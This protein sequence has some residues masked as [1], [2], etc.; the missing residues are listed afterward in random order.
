MIV[1]GLEAVQ[2]LA[3]F[4]LDRTLI[5]L[6]AGFLRRA[7]EFAEQRRLGPE[8]VAWL[9]ALDR[10]VHP[11]RDI[12]FARVRERYKL[13]APVKELLAACRRRMPYLVQ[14]YP[15]VPTGLA[16]LRTRGWRVGVTTNGMPDSQ[17]GKLRRTGL[18]DVIDG[19]AV[20]EAEGIRKP[21]VDLF[22]IAAQR[23]GGKGGWMIGDNLI[24]DI[25]GAQMVGP[26][27]IWINREP[28]QAKSIMPTM[29]SPTS[30]RQWPSCDQYTGKP[31]HAGFVHI[32]NTYANILREVHLLDFHMTD[33]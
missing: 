20:S 21:E 11:H 12:Y 1:F 19:H 28:G 8:D 13:A 7:E 18:A 22:R 14:C 25:Q 4:D 26:R 17:L 29:R 33:Q 16:E 15:A 5:D 2:L 30:S 31:D 32:F 23:C 27:T 24:A 10:D 9:V 3:L 6:D